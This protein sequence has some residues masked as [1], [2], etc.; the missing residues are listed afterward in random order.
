MVGH[1]LHCTSSSLVGVCVLCAEVEGAVNTS[2]SRSSPSSTRVSESM[3]PRYGGKRRKRT[4]KGERKR[5]RKG[6][7]WSTLTRVTPV[8][9][10]LLARGF[11]YTLRRGSLKHNHFDRYATTKAGRFTIYTLLSLPSSHGPQDT[12]TSLLPPSPSLTPGNPTSRSSLYS[13]SSFPAILDLDE[14]L[15]SPRDSMCLSHDQT[16]TWRLIQLKRSQ[17]KVREW[18]SRRRG[19]RER[20]GSE[21]SRKLH[22]RTLRVEGS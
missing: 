22:V 9:H 16:S 7:G 18:R 6:R 12:T 2:S 13:Q 5:E 11:P 3:R 8:A 15:L 1:L 10:I 14:A 21:S 19:I 17:A 4:K 20:K